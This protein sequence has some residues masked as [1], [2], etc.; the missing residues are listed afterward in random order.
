ML[1]TMPFSPQH[2]Y[3]F[4]ELLPFRN[5][6]KAI[7]KPVISFDLSDKFA[8]Y[9][10]DF[11]ISMFKDLP[12][13]FYIFCGLTWKQA[14]RFLHVGQWIENNDY[15]QPKTHADFGHFKIPYRERMRSDRVSNFYG[16]VAVD[17]ILDVREDHIERD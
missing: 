5:V 11:H 6:G 14:D 13:V 9:H 16:A 10:L 2:C 15:Y 4:Y 8:L 7:L 3:K 1:S 12:E 17:D